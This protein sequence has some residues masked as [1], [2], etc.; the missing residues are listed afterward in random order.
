[1]KPT[2]VSQRKL[3]IQSDQYVYKT[4]ILFI[5]TGH[6]RNLANNKRRTKLTVDIR[7][8]NL[9]SSQV[10]KMLKIGLNQSSIYIYP[11]PPTLTPVFLF[12]LLKKK[13]EKPFWL[14]KCCSN[15][16]LSSPKLRLWYRYMEKINLTS[17]AFNTHIY[18]K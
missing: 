18:L 11:F 1:M 12:A 10:R 3:T 6:K 13:E 5:S 16:Y 14:K 4:F 2:S 8:F 7:N 9:W 17:K 15:I